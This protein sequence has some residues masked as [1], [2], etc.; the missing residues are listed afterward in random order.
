MSGAFILVESNSIS[1]VLFPQ[2][3]AS[4]IYLGLVLPPG[5]NDLPPRIGRAALIPDNPGALVYLVFQPIR[6]TLP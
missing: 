1:G 5:S 2:L 4:I 3:R 6:F